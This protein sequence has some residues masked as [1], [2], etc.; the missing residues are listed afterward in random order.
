MTK[1]EWQEANWSNVEKMIATGRFPML[2]RFILEADEPSPEA[3]FE[4]GLDC[5]LDGI[6]V[7]IA[8]KR[9]Q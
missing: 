6:E 4:S 9:Q 1:Q 5:M 8:G 7:Q 3:L 2:A